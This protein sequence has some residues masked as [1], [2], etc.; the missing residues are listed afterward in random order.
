MR[1]ITLALALSTVAFSSFASHTPT[2]PA[3]GAL[4]REGAGRTVEEHKGKILERIAQHEYRLAS[5]KACVQSA[6]THEELKGCRTGH[7]HPEHKV[8]D[9]MAPV[10]PT[11]K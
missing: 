10:A 1:K 2:H 5:H 8:R 6:K 4:V 7:P 3:D 11:D 9:K